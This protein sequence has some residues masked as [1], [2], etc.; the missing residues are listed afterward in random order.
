LLQ[1]NVKTERN[2]REGRAEEGGRQQREYR[3]SHKNPTKS[4]WVIFLSSE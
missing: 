3:R 4:I 1:E 2:E